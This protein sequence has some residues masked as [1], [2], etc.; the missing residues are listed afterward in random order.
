M[1][2]P[3][4]T[5]A[6][7]QWPAEVLTFAAERQLQPYLDPLL[8]VTRRVFPTLRHLEVTVEDDPEI[9]DE[10]YIV[11]W[12]KVPQTDIPNFVEA[13]H[14]W[15]DEVRPLCPSPFRYFFSMLLLPVSS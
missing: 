15:D 9:R 13:V 8:D 10:R 14:R 4:T 5:P 7:W 12:V 1:S 6:V 3:V 11:F 2:A